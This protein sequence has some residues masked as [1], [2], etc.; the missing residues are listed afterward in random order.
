MQFNIV[1]PTLCC[2]SRHA[3]LLFLQR[4]RFCFELIRERRPEGDPKV[5]YVIDAAVGDGHDG[6]QT[7]NAFVSQMTQFG[8]TRVVLLCEECLRT[9]V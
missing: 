5:L 1:Q 7:Y 8:V 3:A 9:H 2:S 6:R 4:D